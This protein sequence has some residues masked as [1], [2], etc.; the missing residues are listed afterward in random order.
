L[1]TDSDE[2]DSPNSG[3]GNRLYYFW[4][5]Y[6]CCLNPLMQNPHMHIMGIN[7]DDKG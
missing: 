7:L 3:G 4:T 5:H 2:T 6:L 1:E